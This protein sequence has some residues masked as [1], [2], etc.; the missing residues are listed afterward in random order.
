MKI[1][2]DGKFY[3]KDN[4]KISVYDHGL[5]Y[6]DGIFEGIRIYNN[7]VFK[8]KEHLVRLYQS[9]KA[10]LLEVPLSIEE[11]EQA[12][13]ETVKLNQMENAY[14]R[15]VVTRGVGDLGMNPLKCPKP[16]IIIIVDNIS[17]YPEEYYTNGI[18]IITASTRRISADSLDPRIKSLNYVNNI[19]AKYEALQVNCLEAIMLNRN[20]YVAE[21]T[22]DNIFIIKDDILYTPDATQGALDGI[23][24][25]TIL[26]LAQKNNVTIK[27]TVLAQYDLYNADECF[28]TGSGAEVL[29]VIEID[30]RKIG[31]GVPGEVTKYLVSKY[32]EEIL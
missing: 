22:A 13:L 9:A 3:E 7:K 4:A 28:L 19:L 8:L 16:S 14:I 15:L 20:G 24:K 27:E 11:L 29:P 31:S 32:K 30:G 25:S 6:G 12:V 23:T 5:L 10:L 21:C 26:E 17:L 2:I 1:Y 18:K